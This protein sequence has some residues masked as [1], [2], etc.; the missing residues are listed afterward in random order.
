MEGSLSS[1][2]RST[3]PHGPKRRTSWAAR[4]I[5][6]E[7]LW[8]QFRAE[9]EIAEDEVPENVRLIVGRRVGR[10]DENVKRALTAAAVIGRHFSF[11]LPTAIWR[12]RRWRTFTIVEKAQHMGIIV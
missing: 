11:K 10:L 7:T 6:S 5:V 9:I 8:S 2:A 3:G 4:P 1:T 12:D